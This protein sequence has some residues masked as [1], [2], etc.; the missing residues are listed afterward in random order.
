MWEYTI[1]DVYPGTRSLEE[2][3]NEMGEK[4]WQY[5]AWYAP[6]TFDGDRYDDKYNPSYL[7]VMFERR[8]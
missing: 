4:G 3:C 1:I 8:K 2:A 5:K 6:S 7:K